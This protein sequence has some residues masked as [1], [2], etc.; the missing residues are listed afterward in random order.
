MLEEVD[1]IAAGEK[2]ATTFHDIFCSEAKERRLEGTLLNPLT[3]ALII[4]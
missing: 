4:I 3:G 1:A 2:P